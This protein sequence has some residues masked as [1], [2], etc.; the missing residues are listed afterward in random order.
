MKWKTY[1]NIATKYF[2]YFNNQDLDS[3]SNL[4]DENV[5]LK[6]WLSEHN[7]KQAVIEAAQNTF[8]SFD[9]FNIRVKNIYEISDKG[10]AC[11]IDIHLLDHEAARLLHVVDVLDINDQGKITEIRAYILN[12]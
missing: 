1:E 10:V 11:E 4:F 9:Q 5:T 12:P 7:G 3:L 2:H 6:D 8:T